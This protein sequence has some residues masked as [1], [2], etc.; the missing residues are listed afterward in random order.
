MARH[1]ACYRV[2]T[3]LNLCASGFHGI[4]QFAHRVLGLS[5]GHTIAGHNDHTLGHFQHQSHF[6]GL[7]TGNLAGIDFICIHYVTTGRHLA[8][9]HIGQRAVH[10]DTHNLRQNQT[11]GTHQ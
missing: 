2:N 7:G 6:I 5:H 9:Q 4:S 10:R 8:E 1:T 11:R 3:V